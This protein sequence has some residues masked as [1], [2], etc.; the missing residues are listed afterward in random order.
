MNCSNHEEREAVGMCVRCHKLI[1]E[2]CKVKINNKYYCKECV[3]EMYSDNNSNNNY[4]NGSTINSDKVKEYADK[5]VNAT[6]E[7]TNNT[8]NLVK[9]FSKSEDFNE[10]KDKISQNKKIA[11]YVL[12]IIAIILLVPKVINN[13]SSIPYFFE[14]LIFSARYYGIFSTMFYIIEFVLS[15]IEPIIIIALASLLFNN[16]INLKRQIR[17]IAPI[18]VVIAF[19][20]IRFVSASISSSYYGFN[21]IISMFSYF[22]PVILIVVGSY[23][24]KE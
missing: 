23:L 13:I 10:V 4:N 6:V 14:E 21:I 15:F 5:A 22:V 20:L 18:V 8:L 12:G 17:I 19:T 3:S 16:F 7:A 1:C 11:N 2:E 24:D 9:D